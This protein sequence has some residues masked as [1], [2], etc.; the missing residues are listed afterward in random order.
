MFYS[1]DQRCI[2]K[3]TTQ[4]DI[5]ALRSLLPAY[6]RYLQREPHTLLVRFVGAHC[7][8]MYG[9]DIYFTVMLNMFPPDQKAMSERYDLKGSWVNRHGNVRSKGGDNGR[10]HAPKNR[11][12]KEDR[13]HG[14]PL[15]QDNDFLQRI[16]LRPETARA[17]A[18]QIRHDV[19]FLRE[20]GRMDYSLLIGVRR[21]RFRVSTSG[22]AAGGE[23]S[24]PVVNSSLVASQHRSHH[25]HF[26]FQRD[27]D[28]ATAADPF[29]READGSFR[30]YMV[31]G[32]GL[33]YI[34]MIDLLQGWTVKKR[35][36]R[37]AKVFLQG[38]DG[39]GLS[40][41][42]PDD[43][44]VRF[45]RRCVID[46]FE[47]LDDA[48]MS[49]LTWA[50]PRRGST[51]STSSTAARPSGKSTSTQLDEDDEELLVHLQ[52]EQLRAGSRPRGEDL[53]VASET[54]SA[55]V[56]R[57]MAVHRQRSGGD[58]SQGGSSGRSGD[59]DSDGLTNSMRMTAVVSPLAP[60][61][62]KQ[63]QSDYV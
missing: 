16:S 34:G 44:A 6:V 59:A 42:P 2:V 5:F 31:E 38:K 48:Q 43:Y 30:A 60:H 61:V 41:M 50:K 4:E 25:H 57:L 49:E 11:L 8:T 29:M 39:D 45:Y 55:L 12:V 40:A 37:F 22:E 63:L 35:L 27:G 52:Q 20:N 56:A 1:A 36:E 24:Q 62:Q 51:A 14:A 23:A 15:L 54:D 58:S 33:Y 13:V 19:L 46:V 28:T 7:I 26:L 9:V 17:L 53:S 21:E 47:H 10:K 32:P 18:E 3:S